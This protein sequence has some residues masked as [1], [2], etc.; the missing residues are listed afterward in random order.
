ML[1]QDSLE[2]I[3]HTA[4]AEHDCSVELGTELVTFEQ[5]ESS[6]TVNLVKRGLS[7]EASDG[8][9]ENAIYKWVIGCDGARGVVR[10]QLGLPFVG[11]TRNV[12]NFIVGDIFV[13]G[14]ARNVS[15]KCLFSQSIR[16][17]IFFKCWHMWG[18]A[19]DVL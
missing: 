18:D 10:K 1:G 15:L 6:V 8:V 2:K 17:M 4:L 11:E 5:E 9:N 3:L 16:L 12:E 7:Q 19:S 14:L 13:Q